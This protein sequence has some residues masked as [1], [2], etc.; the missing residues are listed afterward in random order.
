MVIVFMAAST[1]LIRSRCS[2]S[3]AGILVLLTQ[4]LMHLAPAS[5][6][7]DS[8]QAIVDAEQKVAPVP[9]VASHERTEADH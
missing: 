3:S 9:P 4:E 7:L 2:S 5:L 8:G 6:L 1:L